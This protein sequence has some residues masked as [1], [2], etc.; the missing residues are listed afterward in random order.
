[1]HLPYINTHTH[2]HTHTKSDVSYIRY[3]FTQSHPYTHTH[4]HTYTHTH[5]HTHTHTRIYTA[6]SHQLLACQKSNLCLLANKCRLHF[7]S[8]L[9]HIKTHLTERDKTTTRYSQL[10]KCFS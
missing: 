9:P 4:T 2:T 8:L 3:R 10:H 5:T 1:T 7:S 6:V